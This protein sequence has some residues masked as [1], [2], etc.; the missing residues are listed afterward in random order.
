MDVMDSNKD[1]VVQRRILITDG[2]IIPKKGDYLFSIILK[3]ECI[4][5]DVVPLLKKEKLKANDKVLVSV[6]SYDITAKQCGWD[7]NLIKTKEGLV[8][9]AVG[10]FNQNLKCI[11]EYAIEHGLNVAICGLIP[12]PNEQCY[13]LASDNK[14]ELTYLL[15]SLFEKCS[16]EVKNTND[17]FRFLCLEKYLTRGCNKKYKSGQL[18]IKEDYYKQGVPNEERKNIL[19]DRVSD[20]LTR[21][22]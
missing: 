22:R 19:M 9:D 21:L 1:S 3:K 14:K 5:E 2:L 6:G 12:L 16:K 20:Y 15:S 18:K 10:E 7:Y 17:K 11:K 4:L 13:D 8:E